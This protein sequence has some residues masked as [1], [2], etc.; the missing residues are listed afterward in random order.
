MTERGRDQVHRDTHALAVGPSRLDWN[1]RSLVVDI[2]ERCS[3]LP[4]R[5]RGQVR[6]HPA[7]LSTFSTVLDVAGRH[8]WGPI[9]PCA[10]VEVDLEQPSLR[11]QGNAYF[12]SNEGDEPIE[13]GFVRWDWLRAPL[14]DGRCAVLYDVQPCRGDARLIGA[15]FARDGGV[16]P[17]ALDQRHQLPAT[18]WWRVDRRVPVDAPSAVVQRTLEDTPFY[19][20][21]LLR[22]SLGGEPVDAMHETLDVARLTSPAVQRLLPWRMPR[23]A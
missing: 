23:V 6:L 12:D 7:G 20:R 17:F 13:R 9:A 14:A 16:E 19:A 3:P 8:R 10:R 4:R 11:W 21:S 18:R 1:G 15:R 22:M 5:V 2:D